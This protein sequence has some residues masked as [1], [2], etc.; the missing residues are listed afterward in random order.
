MGVPKFY[1]WIS[2]RYPSISRV[3]NDNQVSI[4][5]F[6]IKYKLSFKKMPDFD[7]FYLDM[8]GIIHTCSHLNEDS[9]EVNV[10]EEEIFRNIFHYIDVSFD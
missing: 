5:L 8:N 6:N 4:F 3:I 10:T 1:R 2:E 9:C 7:N